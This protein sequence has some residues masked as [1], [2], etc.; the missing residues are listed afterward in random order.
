MLDYHIDWSD[1]LDGDVIIDSEWIV[2]D[3]L[4]LVDSH[5]DDTQAVAWVSGGQAR[6]K[7][8]MTNRIITSGSRIDDRTIRIKCRHK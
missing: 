8:F 1:W 4:T 6:A 7:Y 5:H 3:G 2:E